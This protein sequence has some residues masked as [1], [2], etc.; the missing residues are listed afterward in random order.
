[1]RRPLPVL[2][3]LFAAACSNVADGNAA[4]SPSNSSEVS[5]QDAQSVAKQIGVTFPAGARVEHAD[6]IEGRDNAARVTLVMPKADWAGWRATL[7]PGNAPPFSADA[8]F[9][10]G[11]DE[12]DWAPG[13]VSGLT[14][15]QVPWREGN[16]SLNLGYAPTSDD[17]VRVFLFWHQ[18]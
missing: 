14:T 8:N 18:L 16:E 13:K 17:Q 5:M 12:G 10:L 4:T 9:H 7:V 3:A 6:R 2:L 1:M 15:V 11:P